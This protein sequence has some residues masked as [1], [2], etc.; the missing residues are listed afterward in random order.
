MVKYAVIVVDMIQ[1]NVRHHGGVWD[2]AAKVIPNIK[3]LLTQARSRGMPVIYACDSFMPNDFLF[4]SQVKP[5]AIRG[6]EGVRVIPELAPAPGDIIL[7]KRRMSSFF[8]TDLDITLRTLGVDTVAVT[9]I[10]T[11][12]CVLLTALDGIAHD[13]SAV[14]IEDCSAAFR[15]EIHQAV[16]DIYRKTPLY[17][18]LR[19]MTAQE[20]LQM[21]ETT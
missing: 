12:V 16:L 6:T 10:T 15:P 3:K 8:K 20:F 11:N 7:E 4:R 2:E 19:V 5:H 13:F 21:A 17:P 18:L 9:G 1:D 14:I